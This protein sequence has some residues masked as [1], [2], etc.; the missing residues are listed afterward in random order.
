MTSPQY[1]KALVLG[2]GGLVGTA[3][4]A[5]LA[6]GLRREG[7]DLADA[8]L[9]VGTSAGAI[10]AAML[11]TGRDLADVAVL[12][13]PRAGRSGPPDLAAMGQAFAMLVDPTL[14]PDDKRRRAG[15]IALAAEAPSEDGHLAGIGSLVGTETWPDRPLLIT[16]VDAETGE[17]K[18]WARGGEATLVEAVASSS[19]FPGTVAP[20]TVNGRRYMDGAL[21]DGVNADLA[22][23]AVTRVL[24]EPLAD[25]SPASEFQGVRIG[26]D[27]EALAAFGPDLGNREA[28]TPAYRAG[29]RQAPPVVAMLRPVWDAASVT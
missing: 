26:P 27:A 18:V 11:T 20:I 12:P 1:G 3:W 5:G 13:S 22:A 2:A 28:W 23:T 6:A 24:V 9:I 14:E 25:R 15:Q 4:L 29:V 8:D 19:A 17:P 21:R 16:A 10:V 7:I